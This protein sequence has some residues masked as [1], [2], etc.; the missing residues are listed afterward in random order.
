MCIYLL[1]CDNHD[2][3]PVLRGTIDVPGNGPESPELKTEY[4]FFF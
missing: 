2:E 3:Q 1:V 4:L